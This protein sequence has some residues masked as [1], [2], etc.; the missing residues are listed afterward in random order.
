LNEFSLSNFSP[1]EKTPEIKVET[2]KT[3]TVNEKIKDVEI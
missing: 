1:L 3:P 2:K